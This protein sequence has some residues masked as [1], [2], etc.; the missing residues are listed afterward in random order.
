MNKLWLLLPLVS[1]IILGLVKLGLREVIAPGAE[2][3]ASQLMQPRALTTSCAGVWGQCGGYNF[4]GATC[5]E[6]DNTCV[7]QNDYYSQ[8]LPVS[9]APAP[10]PVKPPNPKFPCSGCSCFW[11]KCGGGQWYTGPTCCEPG[12]TC[13]VRTPL[14]STCVPNKCGGKACLYGKCGGKYSF[15]GWIYDYNGPTNCEPGSKCVKQNDYYSQC[16]P[17]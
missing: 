1:L 3:T 5:C 13:E 14:Y 4:N 11:G 10:P 16:Q 12:S 7:P 8:C 15:D 2:I 9:P 6:G 17:E